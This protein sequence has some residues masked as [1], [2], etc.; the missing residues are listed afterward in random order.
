MG[1]LEEGRG[2]FDLPLLSLQFHEG[3]INREEFVR[4]LTVGQAKQLVDEA[5][6]EA[7]RMRTQYAR[8]SG[9]AEDVEKLARRLV[10]R[11]GRA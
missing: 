5:V 2:V 7:Q 3:S 4:G 6:E 8:M 11:E 9:L 10:T 1:D